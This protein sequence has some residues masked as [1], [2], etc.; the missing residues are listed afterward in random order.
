MQKKRYKK[1]WKFLIKKLKVK[2]ELKK[3]LKVWL[4]AP[5]HAQTIL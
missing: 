3:L 1:V 2:S 5:I 4:S